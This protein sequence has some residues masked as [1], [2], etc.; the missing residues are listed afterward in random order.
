MLDIELPHITRITTGGN[1][2]KYDIGPVDAGCA[3]GLAS[4]L[5][6]VLLSSLE[7][8]AI[9]SIF[10]KGVQHEFQDIPNAKE[11]VT[12]L[13][14]NIKKVRLRSYANHPVT[15][16][17]AVQGERIVTAGDIQTP[18]TIEVV[19]PDLYLATLDNERAD[20]D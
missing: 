12:D 1:S 20:L 8:A 16:R 15:V 7:G 5:R 11:D 4:A 2:A 9:T 3:L 14:Q 17:L 19:N 13:A 6:R 18:G 10:I